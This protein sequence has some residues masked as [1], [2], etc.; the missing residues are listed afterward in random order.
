MHHRQL[1]CPHMT[2]PY[3]GYTPTTPA[4]QPIPME[5]ASSPAMEAMVAAHQAPA[6]SGLFMA[7]MLLMVVVLL[8]QF[9]LIIARPNEALVFT[10]RRKNVATASTNGPMIVLGRGSDN[11]SPEHHGG[12]RGRAW[13]VPILAP[14]GP[15]GHGASCPMDIAHPERLL[16]RQHP[17]AHPRHRQR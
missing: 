8:R 1:G 17:A 4:Y 14:R 10:G 6:W 12:G 9:L 5:E 13:R 16:G 3:T 7:F 15:H 2:Q 11:Q